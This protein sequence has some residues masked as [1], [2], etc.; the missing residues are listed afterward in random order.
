MTPSGNVRVGNV[1][2]IATNNSLRKTVQD[3]NNIPIVTNGLSTVFVQDVAK[4]EDAADITVDYALVNGKRSVYI[5]VVKTAD[6][7]TLDVVNNL[8]SKLPEMKGLLP[9]DVNISYE[10]DQSAFVVN[11][12]KIV[13]VQG[14]FEHCLLDLSFCCF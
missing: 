9:D 13:L 12:V 10:F 14:I 5:P 1:M 6:A 11:V 2:Y 7:S 3:F 4:V 8:K